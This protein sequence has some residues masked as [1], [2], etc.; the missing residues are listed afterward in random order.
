MKKIRK[1]QKQKGGKIYGKGGFGQAVDIEE[2]LKENF[3]DIDTTQT[4]KIVQDRFI[5]YNEKLQPITMSIDVS[6]IIFKMYTSDGNEINDVT[7][8][9]EDIDK[10]KSSIISS[11][12]VGV[13]SNTEIEYPERIREIAKN[14]I[15]IESDVKDLFVMTSNNECI[16]FVI[17][18]GDNDIKRIYPVYKVF[19]GTLA[20]I[21]DG[22]S[23]ILQSIDFRILLNTIIRILVKLHNNGYYHN[24][25]KPGNI[26]YKL[27]NNTIEYTL[28]DYGALRTT[29]ESF[30]TVTPKYQSMFGEYWGYN[31]E[32]ECQ[33]ISNTYNSSVSCYQDLMSNIDKVIDSCK[34]NTKSNSN[35]NSNSKVQ[36]CHKCTTPPSST[37]SGNNNMYSFLNLVNASLKY[38]CNGNV[39]KNASISTCTD[40][41]NT[42][43]KIKR[44][45]FEKNDLYAVGITVMDLETTLKAKTGQVYSDEFL[46][47]ITKL[48]NGNVVEDIFSTQG[49]LQELS[50]IKTFTS[51]MSYSVQDIEKIL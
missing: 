11:K 8:A 20:E 31:C 13:N 9:L 40:I 38:L 49:A 42:A 3:N 46:K 44:I 12:S 28:A 14:I 43:D 32:D 48:V 2:V 45:A 24:D 7:T 47:F 17:V 34:Q 37:N 18:N 36:V 16:A 4:N 10:S 29:K 25:I 23:K 51:R 35:T 19:S 30:E 26:F 41:K 27:N 22:S 39:P 15:V 6:N 50:K 1:A 5:F 33:K 21:E